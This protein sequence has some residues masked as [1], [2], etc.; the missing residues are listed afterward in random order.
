MVERWW[1]PSPTDA[2]EPGDMTQ[3]HLEGGGHDPARLQGRNQ[4]KSGASKSDLSYVIIGIDPSVC[5]G[6]GPD[7]DCRQLN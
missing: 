1:K 5:H 2:L 7:L 3:A 4:P 6:F